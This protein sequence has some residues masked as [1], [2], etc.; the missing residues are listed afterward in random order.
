MTAE[1]LKISALQSVTAAIDAAYSRGF[2]EGGANMRDNILKAVNVSASQI[3]PEVQTVVKASIEGRPRPA[4]NQIPQFL[5]SNVRA[6]RGLVRTLTKS[7]LEVHP[8]APWRE[9]A[10]AVVKQD[11][12]VSASSVGTELRR[13]LEAGRYRHEGALYFLASNVAGEETAEHPQK[14]DSAD[15]LSNGREV[16]TTEPP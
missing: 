5:K 1:E 9:I 13:G 11:G 3:A 12:S 15:L 14:D 8:G 16:S 6:R 4:R 10:D 7:F 2:A